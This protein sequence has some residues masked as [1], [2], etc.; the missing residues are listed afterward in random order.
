MSDILTHIY[1]AKWRTNTLLGQPQMDARDERLA[2]YQAAWAQ[3]SVSAQVLGM[4][5]LGHLAEDMAKQCHSAL[6]PTESV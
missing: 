1:T 5:E 3:L 4:D 2:T 6:Y